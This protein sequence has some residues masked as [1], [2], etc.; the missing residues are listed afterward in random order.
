MGRRTGFRWKNALIV[1]IA[2]LLGT[3]GWIPLAPGGW[4]D[5]AAASANHYYISTVA[6]NGT[7]GSI[8]DGGP[9]TSA[10]LYSPIGIAVDPAGDLYISERNNST[11]RKVDASGTISTITDPLMFWQT[12]IVFDDSGNLYIANTGRHTIL[13]RTPSGTVSVVA[14][15]LG[16]QGYSGDG[17]PA[18]SALLDIP[19]AVALDED[20]NLYF[21]DSGNHVVRRVD[22]LTGKIS[23]VA[24]N[25]SSGYSGD[26]GSALDARFINPQGLAFDGDGNLY[27][28]DVGTGTVRRVD[29]ATGIIDTYAGSGSR[30][31][32]GDGGPAVSAQLASPLGIIFDGEG[33][34]Y[35][36]EE[37][38]IRKVDPAG[39]IRTIAGSGTPG[40]SGDGGEAAMASMTAMQFM[41]FDRDGHLLF[42]DANAGVVRKL[43]PFYK[44]SFESNGG[45]A[46]AAQNV[47][48]GDVAAEPAAP[49]KT[50]HTFGGWY[51]DAAFTTLYDFSAAVNE[52][53]TLYAKWTPIPYTVTF[54]KNGGDTE[55]SPASLTVNY[56]SS[57][58]TLPTPPSRAGYRFLGWN[59]FADGSGTAFGAPTV[60]TGDIT[61][62][63]QWT[64]ASPVLSA[65]AGDGQATLTWTDVPGALTYSL[66]RRSGRDAYGVVPP[67]SVTGTV[68][69][70]T[71]LTNGTTYTFAVLAQTSSEA[72]VSNEIQVTPT[73]SPV[74]FYEISF[75]SNGGT[76]VASL[77]VNSG[78]AAL[79]PS[80]PT[81]T[82]HAFGGWY[83]DKALTI[84]YDFSEAVTT[85]LTLYAQWT[86]ISY[87]VTFDKNGGDAEANPSIL[88]V[89]YGS[90]AG[91]L[92]APP[93]RAGYRFDGWNTAADG[94]GASF[95]AS[96]IV[97]GHV[98]LYA[99]WTAL[100]ASPPASS[101]ITI[102]IVDGKG[103]TTVDSAVVNRTIVDGLYEDR[104]PLSAGK[105]AQA[106]GRL[107]EL[108]SD[109]G[110][111][112]FPDDKGKAR[113]LSVMFAN[114]T[115]K[116]LSDS[117]TNAEIQSVHARIYIPGNSFAGA[118]E[119]WTFGI[120]PILEE[121]VRKEVVSKAKTD[122]LTQEAAGGAGAEV[123]AA[124]KP[125]R[126]ESNS[127][128]R[129]I[130]LIL[131]LEGTP[132]DEEELIA[133]VEHEDGTKELIPGKVVDYDAEGKL[134]F[135]ISVDKFG[136]FTVLNLP[137]DLEEH[138]AFILGYGDGTFGPERNLTRAEMAAILSRVIDRGENDE[139]RAYS[140][141]AAGYWAQDEIVRTTRMGLMSGYTDGRFKPDAPITRAEMASVLSRLLTLD[142][143]GGFGF[144]D[145]EG[146]WAAL[147]I[148]KAQAAGVVT[149]Y[150]DGSFRPNAKLT[151]AEAVA[152]IDRLLGRGPLSGAPQQ[153]KDV[154]PAYWAYGYIQEASI[155]HRFEEEANREEV[156]VPIP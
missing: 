84:P 59:T 91:T 27:V 79:E 13:K 47:D 56:G 69:K 83:M 36:S 150:E 115:A 100:P 137:K 109:Y 107:K 104:V 64:L 21:S 155:D 81:K 9:A 154:P 31:H 51:A 14:G 65:A 88:T 152:M 130:D 87:T 28:A 20:G 16:S 125:V 144:P 129:K 113:Y 134:G 24:G 67:D 156:Y 25:G 34:L 11:L 143:N 95:D 49:T 98:T 54:D 131:P 22:N 74:A 50:G 29:K 37:Y 57:P 2:V 75:E 92:P 10:Q 71:G 82:G 127:S 122:A 133:F 76:A 53:L 70:V 32:S 80:A 40:Y 66:Y 136:T 85:D 124:G 121:E 142:A 141:I 78:D 52:D 89:V 138:I 132:T 112:V 140:D 48:P 118:T 72:V 117:G 4:M 97:S 61:V 77:N 68:Y 123:D 43:V 58:G 3:T 139:A 5:S 41:D 12:G 60:V 62:Y 106:F 153:W 149:G 42:S 17:D 8:G 126:I 148:R 94:S 19:T 93:S 46:V 26:G 120:V 38:Y 145:T 119:D 44:A 7:P 33:N 96:T 147:S 6:G 146:T 55:A 105:A 101:A 102:D 111:L 23:T 128:D 135:R 45:S 1:F 110:K 108:G 114:E 73:D 86:P 18:T 103:G 90:S 35:I 39:V 99:Q 151:R 15:S 30:G 63:A 116:L